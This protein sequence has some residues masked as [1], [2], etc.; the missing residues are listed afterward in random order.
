MKLTLKGK[1]ASAGAAL[2]GAVVAIAAAVGSI[3]YGAAYEQYADFMVVLCMLAG[4]VLLGIYALL[5]NAV[6]DWFCLLG[7]IAVG[8]GL[9]L[10]LTN[11]YNVWADTWGNLQQYGS[12]VGEFN[13]FN[14]QGGPIPAVILIALGLLS[15]ICGIVAC[16]TG[17]KE[18]A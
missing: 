17:K 16:F 11:S 3:A 18:A 4:A 8:F 9:G 14:S 6:T 2:V 10:F 13:F 15:A 12:I 7:V 1:G 5:D